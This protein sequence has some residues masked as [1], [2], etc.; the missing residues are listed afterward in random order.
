MG[1]GG[2]RQR[3]GGLATDI[4]V[5]LFILYNGILYSG[6]NC[7]LYSGILFSGLD[8]ILVLGIFWS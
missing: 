6:L 2:D 5:F 8:C 3:S 1:G 7:N 4:R